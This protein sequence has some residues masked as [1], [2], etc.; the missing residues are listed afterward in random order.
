M[1]ASTTGNIYGIYDMSGGLWEYVAAYVNNGSDRLTNYGA[2]ILSAN[3]K[4]KNVYSMG[5]SDTPALNYEA[6][7]T[8]LGDAIYETSISSGAWDSDTA[9]MPYNINP[10]FIRGGVYSGGISAGLFNFLSHNGA[11]T[12]DS[13]TWRISLLVEPSL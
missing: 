1:L 9:S 12:G 8:I 5:T 11:N 7:S 4:Y 10:W 13:I 6:S 2:S 3:N